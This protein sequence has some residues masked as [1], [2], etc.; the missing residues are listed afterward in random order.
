MTNNKKPSRLVL[1]DSTLTLTVGESKTLSYEV[2]PS[3]A[4]K[5]ARFSSNKKSVATV[6]STGKITAK[7][8]GHAVIAV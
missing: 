4:S 2:S 8:A 6:S 5:S 1:D 3:T 7:K